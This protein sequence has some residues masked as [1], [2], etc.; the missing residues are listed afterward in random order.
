VVTPGIAI[1]GV[2]LSAD[3]RTVEALLGAPSEEGTDPT[4]PAIIIQR[5]EALCLGARYTRQGDLLALDVWVD[6]A[7]VC[8]AAQPTYGA[9]AMDGMTITF[10]STGVDVRRAF[11]DR[12]SR[13]LRANQFTVLVYDDAGVAFYIRTI[14]DRRGLVD[15]ITVFPRGTSRA[16]WA[17]AA[18]GGQ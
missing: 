12:P 5:W 4:N 14:G 2:P 18:W 10:R 1:A 13:V 11:G 7:D 16:V 6:A 3:V 9:A 17:P 8:A 15:A